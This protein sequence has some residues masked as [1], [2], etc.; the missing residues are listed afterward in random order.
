MLHNVKY[1]EMILKYIGKNLSGEM[2]R[3]SGQF[4]G[5]RQ[6]SGERK[7]SKF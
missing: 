5:I 3:D 2:W 4:A 6:E 1:V 7:R